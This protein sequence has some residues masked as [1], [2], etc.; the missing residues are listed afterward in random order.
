MIDDNEKHYDGDTHKD[1]ERN[2]AY[3]LELI[4]VAISYAMQ[5]VGLPYIWGGNNPVQGFDCSGFVQE[6]LA[7][8]GVDPSGDQ[9]AQALFNH[10]LVHGT[11]VKFPET[12]AL[13]FFGKD[14]TSISHVSF[15]INDAQMIEAG[16]GGRN[17]K[18]PIDAAGANAFV[19]IRTCEA[20][21]DVVAC[22]YPFLRD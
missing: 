11:M 14:A 8:M 4:N 16:G 15:C 2:D 10:F 19:R 12:G 17:C 3:E 6:I 5:F 9:T 13:M 21:K 20:R 1:D 22:I 7:S 18:R